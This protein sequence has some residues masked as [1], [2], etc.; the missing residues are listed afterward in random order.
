MLKIRARSAGLEVLPTFDSRDI[1]AAAGDAL[2][3]HIHRSI[4]TSVDPATG[5][6]L[7]LSERAARKPGRGG[8]RGYDTGELAD[9]LVRRA[10]TGS[11]RTARV[12]L[13]PPRSRLVFLST[14]E[15]RGYNYLTAEGLAAKAIEAGASE[16]IDEALE[17]G[18]AE[19]RRKERKP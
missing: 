10:P 6:P 17:N 14:E 1:A 19:A 15:R 16:A 5:T 11:R 9:E 8:G 18:R 4:S 2:L 7:P 13:V 3:D 12:R